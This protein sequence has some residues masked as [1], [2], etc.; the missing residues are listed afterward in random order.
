V[1]RAAPGPALVSASLLLAAGLLVA[2]A[3]PAAV[4]SLAT[5]DA[6]S[7]SRPSIPGGGSVPTSSFPAF[8]ACE[9]PDV[10]TIPVITSPA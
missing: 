7:V 1:R 8:P 9:V 4:T 2:V 3:Q 10:I 5:G 6:R